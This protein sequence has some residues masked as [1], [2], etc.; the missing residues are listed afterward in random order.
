M[1]MQNPF[2]HV[3]IIGCGLLGTSL[4]LALRHGKR[5]Q[6]ITGV[7][8]SG[9]PSVAIASQ[10][11]AIDRATQLG[12]QTDRFTIGPSGLTLRRLETVLLSRGI[13]VAS[14]CPRGAYVRR[15]RD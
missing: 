15:R 2:R 4:G 12:F 14:F 1:Q 10:R 11:G 8:R 9:S 7:G 13:L 6:V 5:A 3:V